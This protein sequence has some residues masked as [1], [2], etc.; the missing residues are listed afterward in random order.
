MSWIIRLRAWQMAIVF[1]LICIAIYG[2][3]NAFFYYIQTYTVLQIYSLLEHFD[4]FLIALLT[5]LIIYVFYNIYLLNEVVKKKC[6]NLLIPIIAL[7]INIYMLGIHSSM[8]FSLHMIFN[9]EMY[10]STITFYLNNIFYF[11]GLFIFPLCMAISTERVVNPFAE[12]NNNQRV[13]LFFSFLF[14]PLGIWYIQSVLRTY[15]ESLQD[16][17]TI[18]SY[19]R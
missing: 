10:Y 1:I 12:P 3:R 15:Y 5:G 19:L 2:I 9:F 11:L 7:I 18:D 13:N 14:Y 17:E 16:D 4:F 8:V 6:C